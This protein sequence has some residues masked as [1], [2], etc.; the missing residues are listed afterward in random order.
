M[1]DAT[2]KVQPLGDKVLIKP[3]TKEEVTASGIVL[4]DTMTKD[5]PQM[6]EVIAVGP[7]MVTPEGKTLPMH[8]KV[9]QKVYFTKYGPTEIKIGEQD[10]LIVEEKDILAVVE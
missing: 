8:V 5:R 3:Q 2:Q 7:G 4:P 1:A 6:G 9:G 10:M